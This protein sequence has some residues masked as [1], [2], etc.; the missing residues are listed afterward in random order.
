MCLYPRLIENKKYVSNGKNGG[1]PPVIQD[2][3]VKYVPIGCGNCIECRKQ[4]AREWQIRLQEDIKKNINGKMITLTFSDE[5]IANL[6]QEIKLSGYNLDNEIA[7]LAVRRFLERWRKQYKKSLRHWLVTE[8]GHNGT[9]NIHVHGII[10]TNET[11]ETVHKI[12]G[13]GHTWPRPENGWKKTWVN[14][15]TVNYIIKYVHKQDQKH[16]TYKSKILTSPGIGSNYTNTYNAKKNTYKGNTTTETY[17][18]QQGYK[19]SMPIYWRN[20]IYSEEE[21]EK[22][23]LQ[24]LD[25]QER[26]VMGEKV[27]VSTKEG[28]QRYLKLL[29]WYQEKNIRLGYGAQNDE[30]RWEKRQYEEQLRVLN[31]TKRI[32]KAYSQNT[33]RL[34]PARPVKQKG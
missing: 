29:K 2:R 33:K 4:K 12:W 10:W 15:Q 20:K 1:N 28:E 8:L 27:D 24:R 13:Y 21:R 6:T 17:R 25:K 11:V 14:Q 7:T 34:G 26:W 22:L 23:W 5:S 32:Q 18:T 31:Q 19:I 3:R 9:E 30:L 16:T